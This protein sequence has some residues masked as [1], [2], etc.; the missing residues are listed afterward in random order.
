MQLFVLFSYVKG[1]LCP[2]TKVLFLGQTQYTNPL[3]FQQLPCHYY[4]DCTKNNTNHGNLH[5]YFFQIIE[6]TLLMI[7]G[8][9]RLNL[10]TKLLYPYFETE[11]EMSIWSWLASLKLT[12]VN[13]NF[14]ADI[15][16]ILWWTWKRERGIHGRECVRVF[17]SLLSS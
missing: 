10:S 16:T 17:S 11:F 13:I 14:S 7:R 2:S 1:K 6:R 9:N 5:N 8:V 3:L 15:N 4:C 12:M